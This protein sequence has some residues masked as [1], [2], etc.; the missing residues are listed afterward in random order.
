MDTARLLEG[1]IYGGLSTQPGSRSISVY[2]DNLLNF[3]LKKR[4]TASQ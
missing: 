3:G 2:F 4:G 1:Y